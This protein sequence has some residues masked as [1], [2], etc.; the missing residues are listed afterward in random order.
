MRILHSPFS[1][2][3]CACQECKRSMT[4]VIQAVLKTAT[5]INTK[6]AEHTLLFSSMLKTSVVTAKRIFLILSSPC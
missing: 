6:V 2:S 5:D 4:T 3:E 1:H